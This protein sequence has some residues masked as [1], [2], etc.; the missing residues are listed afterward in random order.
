MLRAALWV[1][2]GVVEGGEGRKGEI[3]TTKGRAGLRVL[4]VFHKFCA[5]EN[6]FF[7]FLNLLLCIFF[8]ELRVWMLRV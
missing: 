1:K 3:M 7:S 6:I 8:E 2:N 4:R 5:A